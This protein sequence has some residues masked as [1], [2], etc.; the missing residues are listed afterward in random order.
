MPRYASFQVK[1]VDILQNSPPLSQANS[2]IAKENSL[3]YN[4]LINDLKISWDGDLKIDPNTGDYSVSYSLEAFSQ[5]LYR[6]LI[7]QQGNY[8]GDESFGWNFEYLFSAP[9][10]TQKN[11]LPYIAENIKN[12]LEQDAE[13]S[14]VSD[15]TVSLVRNDYQTHNIRIEIQVIPVGYNSQVNITLESV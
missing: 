2:L 11:L 9:Y 13:V 6:K 10:E 7:T 12:S 3:N 8:P 4:N 15:V 1:S 5:R 14:S